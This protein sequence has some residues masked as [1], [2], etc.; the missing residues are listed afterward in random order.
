MTLA[1]N[2]LYRSIPMRLGQLRGEK[3]SASPPRRRWKEMTGDHWTLT[4]AQYPVYGEYIWH[5]L[6]CRYIEEDV[7]ARPFPSRNN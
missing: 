2:K 4:N 5:F 1:G 3:G 7:K 6:I